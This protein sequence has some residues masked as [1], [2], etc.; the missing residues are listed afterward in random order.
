MAARPGLHDKRIVAWIAASHGLEGR[1]G[2]ASD[3]VTTDG[4]A[5]ERRAAAVDSASQSAKR[6]NLCVRD[7]RGVD[8]PRHTL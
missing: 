5:S 3:G 2:C 4:E 6:R 8:F 7:G 1:L